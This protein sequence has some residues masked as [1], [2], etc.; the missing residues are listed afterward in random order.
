M[1]DKDKQWQTLDSQPEPEQE[2]DTVAE[3]LQELRT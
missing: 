2:D 3:A 1:P